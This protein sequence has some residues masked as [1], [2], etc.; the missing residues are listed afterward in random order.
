MM[1]QGRLAS[2]SS[3][4]SEDLSLLD[5]MQR[6]L[7]LAMEKIRS[8]GIAAEDVVLALVDTVMS[9]AV[10]MLQSGKRLLGTSNAILAG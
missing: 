4:C 1:T 2:S 9:I 6:I 7:A 3:L 5:A 8:A 10:E